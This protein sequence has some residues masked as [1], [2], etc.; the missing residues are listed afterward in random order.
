[1]LSEID[2][3]TYIEAKHNLLPANMHDDRNASSALAE[4]FQLA[5]A[6]AKRAMAQDPSLKRPGMV[7]LP[8]NDFSAQLNLRSVSWDENELQAIAR[9]LLVDVTATSFDGTS[10]RH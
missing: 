5:L 3:I 1:M 7:G 4:D 2:D 8:D 6:D 9:E 10:N